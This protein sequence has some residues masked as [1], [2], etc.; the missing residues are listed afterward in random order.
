MLSYVLNAILYRHICKCV[1]DDWLNKGFH[2]LTNVYNFLLK[3][4]ISHILGLQSFFFILFK[5]KIN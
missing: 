5:K 3:L 4:L 1:F 2:I